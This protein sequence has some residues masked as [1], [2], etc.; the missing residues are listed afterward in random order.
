MDAC[1]V[2]CLHPAAIA[3]LVGRTLTKQGAAAVGS[4]FE[5]LTDPSR[6]RI[7]HALALA[8]GGELC[9]C[10]LALVLGMSVSAL[11]HQLRWLRERRAVSRRKAGRI[12]YYRLADDRLRLLIADAVTR[13]AQAA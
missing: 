7:V 1:S 8:D 12:A 4:L 10:D 6:A 9:V 2:E 11:S 3:P 5:A 13:V